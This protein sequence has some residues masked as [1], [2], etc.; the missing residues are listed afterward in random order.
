MQ[1]LPEF[2]SVSGMLGMSVAILC[3]KKL[4]ELTVLV[5]PFIT[6]LLHRELR[7]LELLDSFLAPNQM[8]LRMIISSHSFIQ[9][10]VKLKY[11]SF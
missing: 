5:E 1:A 6:R 8:C 7:F 3:E 9:E 11:P 2:R 10:E 4:L